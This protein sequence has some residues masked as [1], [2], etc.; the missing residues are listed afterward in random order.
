MLRLVGCSAFS[1]FQLQQ[2]RSR[3]PGVTHLE[4]LHEHLVWVHADL[5]PSERAVLERLLDYGPASQAEPF[6]GRT[7]LVGPR[8]GT[9]SPWSSKATDIARVCGLS[10]VRRI[11]RVVRYRVAGLGVHSERL[12]ES[13]RRELHDPMTQSV[14]DDEAAVADL[15]RDESPRPVTL[16]DLL[17]EGRRAL[18]RADAGLGLSLDASEIDYL[19]A[20]FA[21][22]GRNPT[23]V[24]LMMFAQANSEH[25]RHKIFRASFRVDGQRESKS[26]FDMIR[27]THAVSPA[28]VL[29]AY[30]DN[31]A[32]MAAGRGLRWLPQG[33]R[34]EYL[35][36]EEDMP[37]LMKCETH[38]H[39]TAISPYPGA[40]TG[41]GGEIRDEAATG[42]GGRSKAGLTG[43]CVSNL[44]IPGYARPWEGQDYGRPQHVQSALDIMLDGPLGASGFNNEFG[45]PAIAGF[46]RTFEQ[47]LSDPFGELPPATRR[48]YHKP[49]ML[50]GGMGSV[51]PTLVAKGAVEAGC[52]LVVMGG[53]ALLIGLGGGAASS[54]QQGQ[55]RAELDFA[56]VQRDNPEMQR[57]CQE[58]VDQCS[59]LG[60]ESPIVSIHDVGAGGLSNALPELVHDQGLG[61]EIE[62]RAIPSGETGLSPLEIWCNEAQER[63]VLAIHP[64]R[65]AQFEAIAKRERCPIARVGRSRRESRLTLT[66]GQPPESAVEMRAAAAPIDLPLDLI[67]GKAPRLERSV[68]RAAVRAQTLD[69]SG[70]LIAEAVE[71]VLTLPSVADKSFLIT[72][73]DR[74]VTGLVT[75]DPMVGPWQVPVADAAVTLCDFRGVA[76][77]AM[78]LGE[79]PPV[80]LADPRAAA[81][82]AVGEALTNLCSAPIAA[83]GNV[84]LS[85][86]WMAACGQPGQDQALLDAVRTVGMELC[87]ALGIAV[88][89][90]KDS[91]SMH[92]AWKDD[93]GEARLVVAPLSLVVTAFAP[94]TDAR[95]V[96]TPELQ[97]V[98]GETELWLVD[99]GAGR[100]RLGGSA[101]AQTYE[102]LG[103]DVP[104]LDDPAWLSGFFEAIQELS[105]RG[106][107]LAYHDRSDGG[108][109]A[110]LCEMCFASHR[111][112]HVDLGEEGDDVLA[113]LFAE[114]LG[115]V[116]QIRTSERDVF[117]AELERRGLTRQ[118]H[119]RWVGRPR[120]DDRFVVHRGADPVLDRSRVALQKLW[121]ETSFRMQAL[122]DDPECARQQFARLDDVDDPGQRPSVSFALD[123][124][125]RTPQRPVVSEVRERPRV[126]ILRDQGVNGHAEMAAAFHHAGFRCHDVHVSDL[127]EGRVALSEFRGVAACG[128]FS[129]GDVLGA[130]RGWAQSI[131]QSEV[132]RGQFQTFFRQEHSF[133]LGVC[134]GCQM[135]STLKEL[136][137]GAEHFPDFVGN[138]SERFEG[139]LSMVRVESTP[140]IFL[141]GMQGSELPVAVAHGEGRVHVRGDERARS[142]DASGLVALRFVDH[143][144]QVTE[145]YPDNPN[146]SPRGITAVSSRNGRVL[147]AMP[148]PERVFRSLQLSHRDRECPDYS[149]WMRLF[150]N[151]MS[152]ATE[153]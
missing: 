16:V 138:V 78:A 94:V 97:R 103:T 31:A 52:P 68:R 147:I 109:L 121:S 4:A 9:I 3:L 110:T 27:N 151:A 107:L 60:A 36:V 146:G 100:N 132:A 93:R 34:R 69:P 39:P 112:L 56:S 50:A 82:L 30:H 49:I 124:L 59:A 150:D 95:R 88:P 137:P 6:E 86:N 19:V 91:L 116:V 45:R 51:R 118:R 65:Y 127:F 57:R 135:L 87:P 21:E 131:L 114:E 122:R 38:N 67:F 98:G 143:R 101:L 32:V 90:G 96:L 64:E 41:A 130:G 149:P 148:H 72:I 61:A 42:R 33:E 48:G 70:V 75:R 83:L 123:S 142:L 7:L 5:R 55:G 14:F 46:F 113:A 10:S 26:L 111:G 40:S 74:T 62:L 115:A 141:R 81:R 117:L 128:G 108:L 71:R 37:V 99:L 85:A 80:A 22:L 119:V 77:E 1:N 11:E 47:S 44:R 23:D 144:R 53:P 126:A 2:I 92:T 105:A 17:G 79:R 102:R 18:E 76:G 134:N 43:F 58:V 120:D 152:F 35:E 25:C 15:L 145:S 66:D 20:R 29:S 89:V 129:Y 24:E 104:D 12:P 133:A 63:F 153:R 73:G 125:G 8:L 140:S 84:K 106:V 139:R 13:V 54:R 136:I 28:G